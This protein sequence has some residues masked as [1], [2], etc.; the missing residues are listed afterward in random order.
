MGC[1]TICICAIR[2]LGICVI[3]KSLSFFWKFPWILS[4]RPNSLMMNYHFMYSWRYFTLRKIHI[5]CHGNVPVYL[6][7]KTSLLI[8]NNRV[9]NILSV[10]CNRFKGSSVCNWMRA[11]ATQAHNSFPPLRQWLTSV[12]ESIATIGPFVVIS[13]ENMSG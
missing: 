3:C 11:E 2:N 5:I 7:A 1:I 8:C 12:D 13:K 4:Y 6:Y 9:V 10:D